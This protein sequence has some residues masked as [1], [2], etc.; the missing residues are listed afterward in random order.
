MGCPAKLLGSRG[1]LRRDQRDKLDSEGKIY[2]H[3]VEYVVILRI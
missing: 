3:A 1:N 2:E